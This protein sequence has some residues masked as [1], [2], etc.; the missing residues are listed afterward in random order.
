MI[1]P[2]ASPVNLRITSVVGARPQFV[3][4]AAVCRAL[5]DDPSIEHNVIH[6]GQHYDA[7]MSDVFF[8]E[9]D[10]PAPHVNLGVGS[11]SHARQTADMMRGLEEAFEAA[12]P[13]WLLVYGDT[14]S[15]LAAALVASKMGIRQAHV[16]A[17][18]RSGN[19][20]MPEELNRI[21][22]D[23]LCDLLLCPTETAMRNLEREGLGGRAVLTGDV[24][25]D[26][27]L[28]FRC[29]A[30]RNGG[31]L[32]QQWKAG[33]FA[34]ATIHRAEN[35]DDPARLCAILEAL[36]TIARD[37]CPV[38]LPLHP[39]TAGRLRENN[40]TPRFVTIVPPA[41][42][43]EMLLLVARAR[44]VLTDS[45]GLQK[46]AFFM[47]SPCITLRDE[48]EWVET[49]QNGCNR[50]VGADSVRILEA[51]RDTSGAGPWVNHYGDG[52][53]AGAIIA[54]VRRFA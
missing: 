50:L 2:S 13:D 47:N 34:L 40:W 39:R 28:L 24:M 4:A 29:A 51:A 54:A 30:E 7:A 49:L 19:R 35:T 42:Y 21:V 44:F 33:E 5:K 17:G 53:A 52:N 14:N 27:V 22:A 25:Y 12:P 23:H 26:A 3:K 9:L 31:A 15:T 37:L 45:G 32:A 38:L 43:L 11:A 16:E 1:D 41:S 8:R 6:T 20:R 48:T 46:E 10:I 18:L 36:D